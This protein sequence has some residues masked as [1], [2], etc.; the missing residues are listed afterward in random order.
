MDISGQNQNAFA[1]AV[2]QY[3][4]ERRNASQPLE[5]LRITQLARQHLPNLTNLQ[6]QGITNRVVA[7]FNQ[8]S[9]YNRV[10]E[11]AN[12]AWEALRGLPPQ[13]QQ[14]FQPLQL[15][16][17]ISN[18]PSLP[19]LP[20]QPTSSIPSLSPPPQPPSS[21][22]AFISSLSPPSQPPSSVLASIPSFSPLLA[23]YPVL[24]SSSSSFAPFSLPF[25]SQ[26]SSSVPTPPSQVSTPSLVDNSYVIRDGY[27]SPLAS[28]S[29]ALAQRTL[30]LSHNTNYLNELSNARLPII[31]KDLSGNIIIDFPNSIQVPDLI[32]LLNQYQNQGAYRTT[33]PNGSMTVRDVT[34]PCTVRYFIPATCAQHFIETS[35]A[36]THLVT[37]IPQTQQPRIRT[38]FQEFTSARG[39]SI[40]SS[41]PQQS[42]S[43]LVASTPSLSPP[44]TPYPI[45]PSFSGSS[46]P[47]SPSSIS[48]SQASSSML[49]SPSSISSSISAPISSNLPTLNL[50]ASAPSQSIPLYP[51]RIP[52]ISVIHPSENMVMLRI[53]QYGPV[54]VRATLSAAIL[55][56]QENRFISET[57]YWR[58]EAEG[59]VPLIQFHNGTFRIFLPKAMLPTRHDSNL[60]LQ[61]TYNIYIQR[62]GQGQITQTIPCHLFGHVGVYPTHIEDYMHQLGTNL[63]IHELQSLTTE[64]AQ[65]EQLVQRL[66]NTSIPD[67]PQG[68]NGLTEIGRQIVSILRSHRLLRDSGRFTNAVCFTLVDSTHIRLRLGQGVNP[69]NY[70]RYLEGATAV[71]P[72]NS[73]TLVPNSAA[74]RQTVQQNNNSITLEINQALLT[75]I[76][77][78]P[79][80]VDP[81]PDYCL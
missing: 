15:P 58:L 8:Y 3:V 25:M 36:L 49:I 20:Q 81:P 62:Q 39:R 23:P 38:V 40:V 42:S 52:M 18:F 50:S 53:P 51:A 41:P 27:L 5:S 21:V 7:R 28:M 75:G 57:E 78:M 6:V 37:T 59:K 43:S 69:F 10:D 22:L 55:R 64:S 65:S 77:Q 70:L 63:S 56:A 33:T 48:I 71:L 74:L 16:P 30:N 14:P 26:A 11:M 44:L 32:P 19:P 60:D 61:D 67:F 34:V 9:G 2:G 73:T 29:I 72:N 76:E 80:Y 45:L 4:Y 31:S 68:E 47:F 13:Q 79:L 35:L 1:D 12:A 66:P 17:P 46:A 54:N 24:P